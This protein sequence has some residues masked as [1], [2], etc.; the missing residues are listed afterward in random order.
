MPAASAAPTTT[1]Y[2]TSSTSAN[3]AY[4]TPATP[5]HLQ[6]RASLPISRAACRAALEAFQF[7]D[8]GFS[9]QDW[10]NWYVSG[11]FGAALFVDKLQTVKPP[12]DDLETY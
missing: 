12:V 1:G 9:L 3:P 4:A 2:S 11:E 7:S 6:S 10:Y 8:Q 5:A